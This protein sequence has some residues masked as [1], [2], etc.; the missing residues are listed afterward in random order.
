MAQPF[1]CLCG[2]ENCRGRISGAIDMT[3]EQLVGMLLNKHI[4][5]LLNDR[6]ALAMSGNGAAGQAEDEV[7]VDHESLECITR[8]LRE[9]TRRAEEAAT[10]A[11]RA[12]EALQ[13]QQ[14]VHVKAVNGMA[15]PNGSHQ[16]G[17]GH[18]LAQGVSPAA[19]AGS[20]RRGLTSRELS[21]EMGGDTSVYC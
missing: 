18:H 17:N 5:E 2:K 11:C 3:E 9:A 7:S 21:G 16:N 1:D 13:R 8:E 6:K 14:A 12:L 4:C 10:A 19:V 20:L 15:I